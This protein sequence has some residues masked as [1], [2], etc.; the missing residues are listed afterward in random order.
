[1]KKVQKIS[2]VNNAAFSMNFSIRWLDE[3]GRWNTSEWNS[4]NYP[5]NKS[6]TSPDLSSIGIPDDALGVVVLRII[7]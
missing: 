1:M 3:E 5:I 7:T 4:G 6:R 2:C